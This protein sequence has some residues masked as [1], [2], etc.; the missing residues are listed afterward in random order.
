MRNMTPE[1]TGQFWQ[2]THWGSVNKE[3][4]VLGFPWF[5]YISNH[6]SL[7]VLIST[8]HVQSLHIKIE[9]LRDW[10]DSPFLKFTLVAAPGEL[11]EFIWYAG[12]WG[13][14][15]CQ[16]VDASGSAHTPTCCCLLSQAGCSVIE[17]EEEKE[18]RKCCKSDR[19][20]TRFQWSY[21]EI[22]NQCK[23]RFC[24]L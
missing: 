5:P 21:K 1:Q 20:P 14:L 15:G 13:V 6:Q 17:V 2:T 23:K 16:L 9:T 12:A 18:C 24:I 7:S 22:S 3:T 4:N 8:E 19:E 10:T 11:W